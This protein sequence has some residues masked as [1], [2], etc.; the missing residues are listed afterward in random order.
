MPL[1]YRFALL[2]TAA[3][4][5]QVPARA[6]F[7]FGIGGPGSDVAEA[8]ALDGSTVYV[9]GRFEQTADFDAGPATVARTSAGGSDAFLAAYT[10]GTTAPRWVV[11]L[12]SDAFDGAAGVAVGPDGHVYATGHFGGTVDFDPGPDSFPLT[13]T[14]DRAAFVAS[15]TAAGAFRWAFAL[16]ETGFGTDLAADEAGVYVT[17]G[18]T[19]VADF[20]PG[21]GTALVLAFRDQDAYVAAYT[22]DGA[23]RWAFNLGSN[24]PEGATYDEG[25]GLDARGGHV[26]VTGTFSSGVDFDPGPG[27]A[28][29]ESGI[30]ANDVF[31]ARY[32]TAGA[33]TWAFGFG[34]DRFDGGNDVATDEAGN[35]Y[36][37]GFFSGPADFDPGPGVQI[38]RSAFGTQDG[39][40]ASYTAAGQYRSAFNIGSGGFDNAHA[41]AWD[42]ADGGV[43]VGGSFGETVDFDP[44]P[45]E[46]ERT[47]TAYDDLLDRKS[48]V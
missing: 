26:W 28:R 7:A 11:A 8:V 44:G 47:A 21:P 40:V 16:G 46:A 13:A 9:A 2:L 20:D 24:D 34:D 15:Y 18:F 17:G 25:T 10:E 45:D 12:G 23:Y 41:V 37:T 19:G 14:G 4:A 35:C 22:P 3:L 33:Y 31:V 6:Q 1:R 32:T 5:L 48:V 38:V 29:V 43:Y 27:E 39:F 42:A 36:V 30:G